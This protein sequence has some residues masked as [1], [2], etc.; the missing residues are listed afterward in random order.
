MATYTMQ[1]T[2]NHY[3]AKQQKSCAW[4]LT[5]VASLLGILKKMSNDFENVDFLSLYGWK[6]AKIA[7][8]LDFW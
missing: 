4:D 7:A 2:S 5:F 3:I 1:K 6:T 8:T